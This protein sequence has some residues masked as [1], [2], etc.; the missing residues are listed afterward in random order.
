MKRPM[1]YTHSS[2]QT[3]NKID[4]IADQAANET[5]VTEDDPDI[6][7]IPDDPTVDMDAA[8]PATESQSG[9]GQPATEPRKS[10]IFYTDRMVSDI[11]ANATEMMY[12]SR[13]AHVRVHN[14]YT[15]M[16]IPIS[17]EFLDEYGD[18]IG[19]RAVLLPV[20]EHVP[21]GGLALPGAGYKCQAFAPVRVIFTP[22]IYHTAEIWCRFSQLAGGQPQ[23]GSWVVQIDFE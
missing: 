16:P 4:S 11:G 18:H 1:W 9:A 21:F 6:Q 3:T 7:W 15:A 19:E 17:L 20:S 23:S 8:Q 22:G 14:Q 5:S 12:V 10:Y 2:A 13:S